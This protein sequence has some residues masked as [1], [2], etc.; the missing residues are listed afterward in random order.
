M[1]KQARTKRPAASKSIYQ[2]RILT[3][4]PFKQALLK[5]S[6]RQAKTGRQFGIVSIQLTNLASL[7]QDDG[8]PT[9]SQV[10]GY[11]S[12]QIAATL[13]DMDRLCVED[14]GWF[15]ILLPETSAEG[16]THA[17]ARLKELVSEAKVADGFSPRCRLLCAHSLQHDLVEMLE[18]VGAEIDEHGNLAPKARPTLTYFATGSQASWQSRYQLETAATSSWQGLSL[19][20]RLGKDTWRHNQ[21]IELNVIERADHQEFERDLQEQLMRKAHA[22]QIIQHPGVQPLIDFYM[23]ESRKFF[24]VVDQAAMPSLEEYIGAGNLQAGE[25]LSLIDQVLGVA[26]CLS[27]TVP[28]VGPPSLSAGSL[29]FD[30]K[31]HYV[32]FCNYHRQAL[33]GGDI[34]DTE[35]VEL[36]KSLAT[37]F[38]RIISGRKGIPQEAAQ[39]VDSFSSDKTAAGITLYKA[40]SSIRR[41]MENFAVSRPIM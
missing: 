29:L 1:S 2:T 18:K 11:F 10:Q 6:N 5:Y 30:T 35:N 37:I 32:K 9:V 7:P 21:K 23:S 36:K 40:R 20:R 12:K 8:S 39:L 25:C 24:F 22:L 13:R 17:V 15:F 38:S 31:D 26:I 34:V 28:P 4:E 33:F 41:A 27:T 19:E 14:S 16:T 3:P